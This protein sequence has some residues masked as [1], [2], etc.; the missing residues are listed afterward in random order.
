MLIK[1]HILMNVKFHPIWLGHM[2]W[3]WQLSSTTSA[4]MY[5]RPVLFHMTYHFP[6]AIRDSLLYVLFLFSFMSASVVTTKFNKWHAHLWCVG[7]WYSAPLSFSRMLKVS[8]LLA[9][10]S[11]EDSWSDSDSI[12][13]LA[14]LTKHTKRFN[15]VLATIRGGS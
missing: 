7:S 1:T 14:L 5:E 10:A 9:W 2:S 6:K 4:A 11:S 3:S 8:W 13:R 12:L 15:E